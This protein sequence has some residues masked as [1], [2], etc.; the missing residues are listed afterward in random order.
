MGLQDARATT[1]QASVL[2]SLVIGGPRYQYVLSA[3]LTLNPGCRLKELCLPSAGIVPRE[4]NP[5]RE[6]RWECGSTQPPEIQMRTDISR[7]E[8]AGQGACRHHRENG[9]AKALSHA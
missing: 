1:L 8:H 4:F 7:Q 9:T 6:F 2:V 5:G 3:H